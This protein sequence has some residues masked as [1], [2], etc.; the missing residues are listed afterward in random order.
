LFQDE[1]QGQ[2]FI[3]VELAAT[4]QSR[5]RSLTQ[6]TTFFASARRPP[7]S[8][9][10]TVLLDIKGTIQFTVHQSHCWSG[11]GGMQYELIPLQTVW[12]H[13]YTMLRWH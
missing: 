4:R 3:S 13:T 7:Q 1:H 9:I 5:P 6:K 12:H 2:N 10:P 11:W 8:T